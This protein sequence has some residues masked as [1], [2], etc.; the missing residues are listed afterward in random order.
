MAVRKCVGQNFG[1]KIVK[2]VL[3]GILEKYHV[4]LK[5][6]HVTQNRAVFVHAP[7]GTLILT[8]RDGKRV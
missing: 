8:P 4:E 3:A 2:I 5:D 6:N 7:A 1:D